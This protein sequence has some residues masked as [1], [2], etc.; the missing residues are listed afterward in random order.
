MTTTETQRSPDSLHSLK[1]V[2]SLG[3]T[4]DRN[5]YHL[6]KIANLVHRQF[7]TIIKEPWYTRIGKFYNGKEKIDLLKYPIV[8]REFKASKFE[9]ID[10]CHRCIALWVSKPKKVVI[11][12]Y[13]MAL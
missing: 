9:I 1:A 3:D 10:G 13:V 6:T 4:N 2:V 12:A 11:R 7:K 5:Y 8:L